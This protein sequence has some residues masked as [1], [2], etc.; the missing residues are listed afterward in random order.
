MSGGGKNESV[1]SEEPPELS[2]IVQVHH[3]VLLGLAGASMGAFSHQP[4]HNSSVSSVSAFIFKVV[5]ICGRAK[6]LLSISV[7]ELHRSASQEGTSPAPTHVF[8]HTYMLEKGSASS[9]TVHQEELN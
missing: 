1:S 7:K 8:I 6:P 3:H 2:G 5:T 4:K 9:S